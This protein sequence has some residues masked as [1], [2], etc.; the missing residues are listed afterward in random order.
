MPDDVQ[1]CPAAGSLH[2]ALLGVR[3]VGEAK[4][5]AVREWTCK[6]GAVHDRDGNA[7]KTSW[8]PGGRPLPAEGTS[9]RD[10]SRLSPVNQ[11]PTEVPR[12]RHGRNPPP[13]GRGGRQTDRSIT[14]RCVTR[15]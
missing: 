2:P 10:S 12:E 1:W 13:S 3:V 4:P 9:D 15:S 11:E 7:A 6:C 5:L 8:P 14:L